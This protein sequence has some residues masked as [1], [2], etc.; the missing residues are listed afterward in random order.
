MNGNTKSRSN[1]F[2]R[3]WRLLCT[4]YDDDAVLLGFLT[5]NKIL[6]FESFLGYSISA[7]VFL[8]FCW[9]WALVSYNKNECTY[10]FDQCYP[11]VKRCQS[12]LLLDIS[13]PRLSSNN[14]CQIK[15]RSLHFRYIKKKWFCSFLSLRVEK[16]WLH[17][18]G[19]RK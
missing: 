13:I 6:K 4:Q 5:T 15:L 12:T 19:L 16:N 7:P 14:T 1:V 17:P 10:P 11:L 3:Y 2:S 9:R 8:N 18:F